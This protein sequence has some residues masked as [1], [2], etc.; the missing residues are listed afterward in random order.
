MDFLN[1]WSPKKKASSFK[2]TSALPL[3]PHDTNFS[4]ERI[5]E[6]TLTDKLQKY[7]L[8]EFVKKT[9]K[10][11]NED[12]SVSHASLSID[13]STRNR[14]IL[15]SFT[16]S[17]EAKV[18]MP[19]GQHVPTESQVRAEQC[20][21][22]INLSN[23]LVTAQNKS[24]VL[25]DT[26]GSFVVLI[27]YW[28]SID[29]IS[30]TDDGVNKLNE[31]MNFCL[32]KTDE[33]LVQA[34]YLNVCN[35]IEE[36]FKQIVF[37]ENCSNQA[38][39][40]GNILLAKSTIDPIANYKLCYL[41]NHFNPANTHFILGRH[42]CVSRITQQQREAI[43]KSGDPHKKSLS[44]SYIGLIPDEQISKILE[45]LEKIFNQYSIFKHCYYDQQ[46][47]V[48]P[49]V[50]YINAGIEYQKSNNKVISAFGKI[51]LVEGE[52]LSN[53]EAKINKLPITD[54][55][56][57]RKYFSNDILKTKRA[58]YEEAS[59]FKQMQQF[60]EIFEVKVIHGNE[61]YVDDV[62]A[63][64]G[65]YGIAD[66]AAVIEKMFAEVTKTKK[67]LE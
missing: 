22:I 43:N 63:P 49:S 41:V 40:I 50:F 57:L 25:G 66:S 26:G 5:Q 18:L 42:D 23:N 54:F 64:T 10:F 53:L 3:L 15:E 6:P 60:G 12:L 11:G 4:G 59:A 46:S 36:L 67:Y 34:D 20:L 39:V 7:K 65:I 56:T 19:K 37:I 45:Q 47:S 58:V 48:Q 29:H 62:P 28:L 2:N 9:I 14:L 35:D 31:L 30:L 8:G 55:D 27:L 17:L 61:P 1:K 32:K 33:K 16:K 38:V 52:D 44:I 24:S 13:I 21:D 51:D